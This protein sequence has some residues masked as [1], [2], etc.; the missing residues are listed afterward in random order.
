MGRSIFSS[1]FGGIH[2]AARKENTRRKPLMVLE[3]AP[4]RVCIPLDMSFGEPAIPIVRVGEYVTVGQ[5]IAQADGEKSANV[6][7]SVSGMVEAIQMRPYPWG[8]TAPAIVISN[9]RTD[10]P[11]PHP[12]SPLDAAR[13]SQEEIIQRIREAGITDMGRDMSPAHWKILKARGR[14][15]TLIINAAESD[16]Y[17]TADHRLLLEQGEQILLGAHILSRALGVRHTI[18][19]VE[20]DKLNAVE[21]MEQALGQR[22]GDVAL[23]T[24]PSRYPLGGEKQIVQAITGR[25][26]PPGG[27]ALRAR[28]VVFNVATAFAVAEA[29]TL[30]KPVTHRA[31]TIS[32]GALYR[33]RNLWV[34]IGTL[35]KDLVTAADG[36]REQ[37][38]LMLLGG[39]MSGIELEDITAPVIKN[40][41]SLLCLAGWE[42]PAPQ[43][44]TACIRCGKC[45]SACPMNL[46]PVLVR[47]AL[48]DGDMKR[49]IRLH[50][51]DCMECG[52][53][54][55]TCPSNIGLVDIMRAARRT[56]AN[57]KAQAKE[58]SK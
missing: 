9:D 24:L 51:Q 54:S 33:P 7:A 23:R 50:P 57:A 16:P 45:V 13:T 44:A 11:C 39:P 4:A 6:H 36:F 31:V 3:V 48:R 30:G 38:E 8:G 17:V 58:E 43:K 49:L 12:L 22:H 42:R 26:I 46:A 15:D 25:E 53:C 52:C 32:G 28:C 35:L 37:P 41:N 14:A 27:S 5:L 20:G 56:A 2:P 18:I 34:P 10:T 47:R 55:Y 1:F 29:V 40:T 19:A 21:A